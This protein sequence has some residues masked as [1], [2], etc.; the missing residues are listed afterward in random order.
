MPRS[1]AGLSALVVV[2]LG[3]D[4]VALDACLA[5][6]DAATPAGTQ[7]WIADDAQLGPRGIAILQPWLA[8][9]RLQA[10][11]TRR[12]RPIGQVAHLDEVLRA[13]GD[14][15]VAVVA[16]DA[17]P[18]PG[19]LQ[20]L[21]ACFA[22]D[23]AIATATPWC[24]AGETTAWPRI[25]EVGPYPADSTHLV[26]ACANVAP[27][28]PE[29][30]AAVDHAVLL[31]G[32]ARLRAGGLDAAS[33]GSWY[34]ALIDLSLRCAGLGWRNVLC[35]NAFVARRG[36]GGPSDGD[37]DAIAIRWPDWHRRLATFL[38]H[39]PIAAPRAALAQA[40]LDSK[41]SAPQQDLFA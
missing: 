32:R 35:D 39:D 21:T 27:H 9:T 12:Q 33:Y 31:R 40:M 5:A 38:M 10:E 1:P 7:V 15:D 2:P 19:W 23:A 6:L 28:Y 20:A 18:L 14:A 36:E 3:T 34:A 41:W 11:Y 22:C 25:G 8:K 30:P 24:N 26:R 13:C 37:L 4:D 16:P 17:Q 29:L